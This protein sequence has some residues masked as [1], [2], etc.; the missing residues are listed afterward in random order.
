VTDLEERLRAGLRAYCDQ[1]R[2]ESVRPLTEPQASSRWRALRWLAP[3]A[4]AVA[5]AGVVAGVLVARQQFSLSFS[6]QGRAGV[7]ASGMPRYYVTVFQTYADGGR[8]ILTK[9]VVHNSRTGTALSSVAVPT[10]MTGGASNSLNITAA[11]DDRTFVIYQTASV[12]PAN[13][14]V[15]FD[16][17]RIGPGGRSA[18]LTKLLMNVP[19]T[20]SV[21]YVALSPDGT[22]LAMQEQYCPHSGSCAYTGIRIITLATGR[23]SSWIARHAN[24]A[25]FNVS[26]AGNSAVAFLWGSHYRLLKVTAQGGDLFASRVIASPR[27]EP[28]YYIPVALVTADHRTVITSTVRTVPAGFGKDTVVAKIIELDA[29][30]G[31]LLRV[32]QTITMHGISTGNARLL[33]QEC[34]VLSLGPVGLHALVGCNAFGRLDG[35]VFTP[36]P[37]FPSPSSSG[38]TA[39]VTGAW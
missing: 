35:S 27:A 26:W 3:V 9:A 33:D 32:L 7:A 6:A 21:D 10:L 30:S 29:R 36:L 39:Q 18:T 11:G 37:G 8:R 17:L 19:R 38:I 24:D 23:T 31:R 1:V 14:I 34:N 4:A 28:N 2:P 20:L 16:L 22:R 25:P 12:G 5:V 13:Q 15:W